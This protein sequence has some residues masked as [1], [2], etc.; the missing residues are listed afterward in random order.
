MEFLDIVNEND[1][2]IGKASK[3][4]VYKNLLTHRI[5]HVL[6]FNGKK[7]MALQLRS[8][9]IKF[10]P[11]HWCTAAAGHVSSGETYEQAALRE[12][13]EEIGIKLKLEFL[14]KDLYIDNFRKTG[15]KKILAS[16]KSTYSG[17]FKINPDE[18]EKVEFFSLDKI[19]EMISSGEKIHP[20]L[21]FLLR[22]HFGVK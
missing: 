17:P 6:I 9:N 5:V 15:L 7:E 18:V 21:L 10:C 14:Y 22:K 2:V 13:E 16:F 11:N 19:Q 3:E 4:E 20:E 12:T 1:E 8:K